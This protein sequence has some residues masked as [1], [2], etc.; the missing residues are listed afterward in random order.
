MSVT[1]S[2][3]VLH[4]ADKSAYYALIYD[5]I[6]S[7]PSQ[8]RIDTFGLNHERLCRKAHMITLALLDI[9]YRI[10]IVVDFTILH[11]IYMRRPSKSLEECFAG[12]CIFEEDLNIYEQRKDSELYYDELTQHETYH[13]VSEIQAILEDNVICMYPAAW[14]GYAYKSLWPYL[15]V[16]GEVPPGIHSWKYGKRTVYLFKRLPIISQPVNECDEFYS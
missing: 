5:W 8:H 14:I 7:R 15:S 10:T 16:G 6:L 3:K 13:G 4:D 9:F 12:M 1:D 11:T 2:V